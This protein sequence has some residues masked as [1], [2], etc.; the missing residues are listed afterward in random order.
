[1]FG[2]LP[3]GGWT[4]LHHPFTSPRDPSLEALRAAPGTAIARAY[5]VVLN[6]YEVGGGS[7][8]IHDSGA[9]V[10]VFDLIGITRTRPSSSSASCW[11]RS[12]TARRRTA[13][14]RSVSTGS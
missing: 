8:R 4:P 1:M 10:G 9:A 13:A 6:G 12:S 14:L 7:M 3:A 2:A 11:R 5:D